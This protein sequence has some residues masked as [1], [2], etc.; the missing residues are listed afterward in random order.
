[1]AH[2]RSETAVLGGRPTI[3][4]LPQKSYRRDRLV[5]A[6]VSPDAL[7]T[8]GEAGRRQSFR[9]LVQALSD[10]RAACLEERYDLPLPE[11]RDREVWLG[12]DS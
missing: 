5:T 1:M 12:E 4:P 6:V 11:R 7:A 8:I 9:S 10:I 2:R 3:R